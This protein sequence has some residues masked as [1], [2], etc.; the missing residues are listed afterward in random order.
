MTRNREHDANADAGNVGLCSDCL[1]ARKIE[2]A[3]GSTFYLCE[4]SISDPT[5]PRYPPLPVL[6]C[7]GHVSAEEGP[8]ERQ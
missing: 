2:T 6:Q 8:V 4:R 5:F 1:Y 3:R 7:S